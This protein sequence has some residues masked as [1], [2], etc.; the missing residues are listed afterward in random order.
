MK[1]VRQS[2]KINCA[3]RDGVKINVASIVQ[4]RV[5]VMQ[6]VPLIRLGA[7]GEIRPVDT[8]V[9]DRCWKGIA[10]KKGV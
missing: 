5:E 4:S 10:A 1:C 8:V 6:L 3:E 9:Y 7:V 2:T